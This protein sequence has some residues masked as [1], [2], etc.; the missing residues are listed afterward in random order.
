[1]QF[2][3]ISE[4]DNGSDTPLIQ[5]RTQIAIRNPF[6]EPYLYSYHNLN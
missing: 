3:F 1:M 6:M 2:S 4:D 5:F